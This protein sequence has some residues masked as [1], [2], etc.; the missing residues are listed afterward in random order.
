[1]RT[2]LIAFGGAA[3]NYAA[4]LVTVPFVPDD[5]IRASSNIVQLNDDWDVNWSFAGGVGL[6]RIRLNSAQSR[7]RGYPNL[8]P[9]MA[10][11]TG[12]D[13]P[14]VA[15]FRGMPIRLREGENVNLQATN[16][17]AAATIALLSLA[18]PGTPVDMPR[19]DSRRIRW[20]ASVTTVA[21]AWSSPAN[22]TLDDDLE[23]GVYA[24]YGMSCFEASHLAARIV[25]QNQV[26]R[27][28]VLANQAATERPFPGFWGGF[29]AMGSFY[30]L[31]P[32]FVQGFANAAAA[33][34]LTGYF[35]AAK[36]GEA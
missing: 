8:A 5:L 19:A 3:Q 32:P 15:D 6:T 14:A 20:T 16:G 7:I 25:F 33:V 23:A 30:S 27:P 12:G 4:G 29:G 11:T 9:F 10:A 26:E 17:G 13:N 28:G 1:M 22:I 24:V 31:V 34:T 35:N 36:I 18:R 2:H 21:Y